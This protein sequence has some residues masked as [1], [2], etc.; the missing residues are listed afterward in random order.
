MYFFNT[1]TCQPISQTRVSE[2]PVFGG[3]INFFLAPNSSPY[4]LFF[5]HDGYAVNNATEGN[6][7][8]QKF[9]FNLNKQLNDIR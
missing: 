2:L 5:N 4:Q 8:M 3:E 9:F 6:H 7:E 1:T